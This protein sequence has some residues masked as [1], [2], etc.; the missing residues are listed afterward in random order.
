[1][2][3]GSDG[4]PEGLTIENNGAPVLLELEEEAPGSVIE[5]SWCSLMSW[6]CHEAC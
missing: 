1:M 5:M 2:F 3:M 4:P 6:R